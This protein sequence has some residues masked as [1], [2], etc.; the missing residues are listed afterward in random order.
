MDLPAR[1]DLGERRRKHE[2]QRI[3][4]HLKDSDDL[5]EQED[6]QFEEDE[7]YQ[8]AKRI[9]AAKLAAKQKKIIRHLFVIL[10]IPSFVA[11]NEDS[12]A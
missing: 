12:E 9:K 6:L 8:Q 11:M 4:V 2:V 5:N 7:F 1:E 10:F 3:P